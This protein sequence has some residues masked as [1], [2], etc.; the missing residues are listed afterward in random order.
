MENQE[1]FP[2]YL[3]TYWTFKEFERLYGE[4]SRCD[5]Y[6]RK[7]NYCDCYYKC[8][9]GNG[10][11]R[12]EAFIQRNLWLH[13]VETLK[14]NAPILKVGMFIDT[15]DF[16]VFGPSWPMIKIFDESFLDLIKK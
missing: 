6:R 2:T 11:N 1:L 16:I 8:T 4:L 9:F 10:M 5:M 12:T 7:H 3:S 15:N 13:N 14:Q